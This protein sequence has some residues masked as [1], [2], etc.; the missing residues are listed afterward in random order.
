MQ[1]S[2]SCRQALCLPAAAV[3]ARQH[4]WGPPLPALR[5]LTALPVLP[6]I[7]Q[8]PVE[9]RR[10]LSALQAPGAASR[11]SEGDQ[12]ADS[13]QPARKHRTRET[14]TPEEH[15]AFL[16]GLTKHGR[17]SW[18]K[19]SQCVG[20]RTNK[21]ASTP[22]PGHRCTKREHQHTCV[23][24][25]AHAPHRELHLLQSLPE[26]SFL[27][28]YVLPRVVRWW[29]GA[30][31]HLKLPVQQVRTHALAFFAKEMKRQQ[32]QQQ[33]LAGQS[34]DEQAERGAEHAATAQ[35]AQPATQAADQQPAPA[36]STGQQE[37]PE[38]TPSLVIDLGGASPS[39]GVLPACRSL[40]LRSALPMR[41]ESNTLHTGVQADTWL[42]T[43]R[44]T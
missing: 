6:A 26:S 37:Q 7:H 16:A 40:S 29:T 4:A 44:S 24:A 42:L 32:P 2:D 25:Q 22:S 27:G 3:C 13:E 8:P 1:L 33:S 11:D 43:L 19:I 34:A 28:T 18:M 31:S 10:S 12:P 9:A 35:A 5:P 15:A 38:P 21:Q 39:A 17:G 14:W 36:G 30:V 41:A 20:T 23:H